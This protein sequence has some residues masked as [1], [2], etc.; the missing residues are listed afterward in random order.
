MSAAGE[1]PPKRGVKTKILGVCL[2]FLGFMDSML[3]WRGGFEV[4]QL[5]VVFIVAGLALVAI[6]TLRQRRDG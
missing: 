1:R 3:A 6:G 5:Y 2:L 4:D